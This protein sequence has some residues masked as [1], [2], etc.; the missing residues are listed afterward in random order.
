MR[1][2]SSL[3][4]AVPS[5]LHEKVL[6]LL[7][8]LTESGHVLGAQCSVIQRGVPV[9][10]AAAGRMG[11]VDPRPVTTDGLFQL[12]EAGCPLLAALVLQYAQSGALGLD[13]T[14]ASTWPA[15]AAG[16][17]GGRK[18]ALTVRQLLAHSTT[19]QRAADE[20]WMR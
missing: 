16:G 11:P 6:R 1:P 2:A 10:D 18:A 14:I 4:S 20:S 15:F 12:F 7:H 3:P 5:S 17:G 13:R 8:S 9:V 19:L